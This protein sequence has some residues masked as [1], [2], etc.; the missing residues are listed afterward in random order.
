MKVWIKIV[1]LLATAALFGAAQTVAPP[2]S[3]PP[4]S[5]APPST[6]TEPAVTPQPESQPVP[7]PAP[8]ATQ[9]AT[10]AQTESAVPE[11]T[12]PAKKPG[13]ANAA[14][15]AP[16]EK[17][18]TNLYVIGPLDVLYIKIWN[19]QN[20]TGMVDVQDDGTI[21]MPLVGQLKADGLTIE[22]LTKAISM[23]LTAGDYVKNPEVSVQVTKNNS[24]MYYIMGPGAG[25]PGAFP[26]TR[27]VTISEAL[28]SAGGMTTFANQKKIYLLRKSENYSVKH[29]FNYKDVLAGKNM[30]KDIEVQNGDRI[31]IPE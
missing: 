10:P 18:A 5:E 12:P 3:P 28:T 14:D 2:S 25:R 20:L 27:R 16:T 31:V 23:K 6:S 19:N 29:M 22:Q 17:P 11:G 30:D 9:A 1:A 15:T 4:A 21:S 24:H 13:A 8:A 7:P 26:L